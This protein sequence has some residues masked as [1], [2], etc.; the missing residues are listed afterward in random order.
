TYSSV[1][2]GMAC[3]IN[4]DDPTLVVAPRHRIVR[5]SGLTRD[6]VLASAKAHF[7][8][9]KLEGKALAKQQAALADTLAHQP[10][11]VVTFAGDADAWKLTLKP[12][13]TPT[14]LGISVHRALQKY[15]P[16]VF[17][18]MFLSRV[19]PGAQSETALDPADVAKAVDAGAEL[20][21]IL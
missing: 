7:V 14:A 15:D 16:I 13:V 6:A 17:E 4:V 12:D 9:E 10:A 5:A 3:L 21:A 18:Q 2:Y 11:F 1:N 8:I 20:G 19:A